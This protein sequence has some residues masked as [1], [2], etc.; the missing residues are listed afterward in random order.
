LLVFNGGEERG[1]IKLLVRRG[2]LL[3]FTS[4]LGKTYTYKA[5]IAN[6]AATTELKGSIAVP[7]KPKGYSPCSKVCW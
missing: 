5:K 2:S 7:C 4:E 6:V 1:R 3:A